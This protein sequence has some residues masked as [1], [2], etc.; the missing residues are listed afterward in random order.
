MYINKIFTTGNYGRQELKLFTETDLD[1]C[2][3]TGT[4]LGCKWYSYT[5]V[6]CQQNFQYGT[7]R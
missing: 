7:G 5:Y 2:A 4:V 1:Y 6:T 3:K